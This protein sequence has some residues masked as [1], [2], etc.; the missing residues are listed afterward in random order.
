MADGQ[1]ATVAALLLLAAGAG[2][3][4]GSAPPPPT[5]PALPPSAA[6][7]APVPAASARAIEERAAFEARLD[8]ARARMDAGDVAGA[9]TLLDGSASHPGADPARVDALRILLDGR[10]AAAALETERREV[11]RL[12]RARV[13]AEEPSARAAAFEAAA[14]RARV[15]LAAHASAKD[16]EEIEA[17]AE[18]AEAEARKH[19]A[20][21]EALAKA[22]AALEAGRADEAIDA[23]AAAY[24]ALPRA[25]AQDLRA[26][27]VRAAAPK[28]MLLVPEGEVPLGR[29]GT[30]TFVKAFY[31]DRTEVTCAAYADFLRATGRASPGGW[32]GP[33]PPRG[34]MDHP[35]T[36]VSG[37]D[38]AA[39]AAWA[40][41]RLPTEV[42]WE[43]AARGP[44]GRKYPWG[45]EFDPSRGTFGNAGTTPAGSVAADFSYYG[46]LDMGGNVSEFTVAALP[47][48]KPSVPR[49]PSEE[50][51]WVA[52]GGHWAGAARPEDAAL[53][54]RLPFRA[55]EKDSATG[56]RCAKDAR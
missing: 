8:E 51:V 37:E 45:N 41:R 48:R 16:A 20:Y 5:A 3:C 35:V 28:G 32:T 55:A 24:A 27:A 31:M 6:A 34:K 33:I 21:V 40:G 2:A 49:D 23:A 17:G 1:G 19:R 52:K 30:P 9:R 14:S 13:E 12:V 53:F 39:F 25:E 18:Y 7:P 47:F 38:A 10:S 44:E 4:G 15:F 26:K 54:L 43:K 22:S 46:L 11:A 42:E 29:T 36:G 56:F 50:P